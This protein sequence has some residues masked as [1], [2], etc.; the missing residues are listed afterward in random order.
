MWC[1]IRVECRVH[2]NGRVLE[3]WSSPAWTDVVGLSLPCAFRQPE[4][5]SAGPNTVR[6]WLARLHATMIDTQQFIYNHR[7][8]TDNGLLSLRRIQI[9]KRRTKH[10]PSRGV[11]P[12]RSSPGFCNFHHFQCG[13]HIL[14]RDKDKSR[15]DSHGNASWGPVL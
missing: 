9:Q 2:A 3:V 12:L 5:N 6:R 10:T 15:M 13:H 1:C 7:T 14:L 4:P 8:S 11:V